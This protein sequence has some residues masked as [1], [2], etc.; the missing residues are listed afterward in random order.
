M[1]KF[2]AYSTQTQ[3]QVIDLAR[4]MKRKGEE[5]GSQP[6]AAVV[7]PSSDD[8]LSWDATQDMMQ[9]LLETYDNHQT[10][11]KRKEMIHGIESNIVSLKEA[12]E[13]IVTEGES[14]VSEISEKIQECSENSSQEEKNLKEQQKHINNLEAEVNDIRDSIEE[15]KETDVEL[16]R[17][18]QHY[19]ELANEKI[20]EMDEVELQKKEEVYRLQTQ[21]SLHAHVTG[22]KWDY[23]D[24]DSLKGEIDIPSKKV[25][26]CFDLPKEGKSDFELVNNFWTMME[27]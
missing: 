14:I 20:E 3:L 9:H 26:K 25:N 12:E 23:E 24:I 18:I 1:N 13:I 19:K 15:A 7:M 16:R 11:E 8:I 17:K 6:I 10:I 2:V 4:E 21:I 5:I 27:A 22:I